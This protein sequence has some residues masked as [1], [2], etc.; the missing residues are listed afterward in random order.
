VHYLI[1]IIYK[2]KHI[3]TIKELSISRIEMIN[4]LPE[5]IAKKIYLDH[6][7]VVLE[8]DRIMKCMSKM[9]NKTNCVIMRR[10]MNKILDNDEL[11]QYFIKHNRDFACVYYKYVLPG[12]KCFELVDNII[13]SHI[14]TWVMHMHH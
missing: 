10:H 13:D 7:K 1:Y 2:M 14:M 3:D 6:F 8:H 11:L 5:D 12:V 4:K 9:Y